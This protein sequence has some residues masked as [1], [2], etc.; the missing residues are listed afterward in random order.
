MMPTQYPFAALVGLDQL[1]TAL[2]LNAVEPRIG[3]VLI[4][5]EK[6]TAKSTAARALRESLPPIRVVQGCPYH[7]DPAEHWRECPHCGTASERTAAEMPVPFAGL[8]I[9]ATEDR[10]LGTLD[11]ERALREGRRAFQPGLLAQA[12]RGILYIDEV[13]LL[14]DHLVDVLLD[15]AASGI[16]AV[17]R[18]GVA[19]THPARFLLVGTMNPEEGDLRPQLLDRFGLMATVAGPRD[20]A[21]RAE[22][23]RRRLDFERDPAGF[24]SAWDGE[25]RGL[26]ERIAAARML[27]PLVQIADELAGFISRLCCEMEVD[28][29][30]ADLVMHKAARAL[31][32]W[33][34]RESVALE[35][36][37]AAAEL[38]LPHR[39]RRKP[40]ERPGL[41]PQRLDEMFSNGAAANASG[42]DPDETNQVFGAGPAHAVGRIEV[43][44]EVTPAL[45]RRNAAERTPGGS[46]V[47]PTRTEKAGGVAV[48]AT[49]RAA[50][51]RGA[52]MHAS[53][54]G[55]GVGGE[56]VQS[57]G[58]LAVIAEDVQYKERGGKAGTLILFVVDASG[59]MAAR[60]RMETV[61]AAVLSLL[62]DAYEQRDQVGVIAFRG[63][64]AELLL[65]PTRSTESAAEA[66]KQLPTGGRT[67]L[68]HALVLARDT[69]RTARQASRET[70][71]LLVVVSDGKANVPLPD[72]AGDGWGQALHAA[73]ALAEERVPALVLDAETGFVRLGRAAKLA[74][75]LGGECLP[76]EQ[77]STQDLVLKIR[78]GATQ[79]GE[80]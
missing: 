23:V 2:L 79:R 64:R 43:M 28:G 3:G 68:A 67:P 27:L 49:I 32:A 66:L 19:V 56:G 31:A 40:L 7:C 26:R 46:Y 9:G 5:G 69:V 50:A 8:P 37:R 39:R 58:K 24:R 4:R 6:G 35:D 71:T 60:R 72:Q 76:L 51:Q 36:I 30:R 15:A 20:P 47:R 1:K 12:H 55:G 45:G 57:D 80:K 75:A 59:S 53:P 16:N 14:P 33:H 52:G 42:A 54:S 25:Q 17:E 41:D 11:F 74:E 29:L 22:V 38:V 10:V 34:E 78:A 62:Q 73:A 61:K 65:P 13:N 63:I 21:V 77:L 48:D 70:P 44:S 18:E